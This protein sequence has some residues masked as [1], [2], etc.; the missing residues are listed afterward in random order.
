MLPVTRSPATSRFELKEHGITCAPYTACRHEIADEQT[1]LRAAMEGAGVRCFFVHPRCRVCLSAVRNYSVR[2]LP[3]G[4]Y[5]EFPENVPSNHRWS[6]PLEAAR[7]L[8][9]RWRRELRLMERVTRER[10][11]T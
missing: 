10:T 8:V 5:D 6:H 4:S 2:E 1:V 7:Y 3:D 9:W 11:T